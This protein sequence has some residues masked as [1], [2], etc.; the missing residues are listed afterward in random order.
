MHFLPSL[1]HFPLIFLEEEEA[2]NKVRGD[3]RT[4]GD[5]KSKDFFLFFNLPWPPHSGKSKE[6]S[7]ARCLVSPEL[8]LLL[9]P[10]SRVT[11]RVTVSTPLSLSLSLFSFSLSCP[12]VLHKKNLLLLSLPCFNSR[13]NEFWSSFFTLSTRKEG[14][15][16]FSL[17]PLQS[18]DLFLIE[19]GLGREEVDRQ[20][21]NPGRH[22]RVV[23]LT[24][25]FN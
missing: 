8:L 25:R 21:N 17:F 18:Q 15:G 13:S 10:W 16:L 3:N 5:P 24:A 7:L 9:L 20:R 23:C 14:R 6:V 12:P 1:N 22:V 4:P 19:N 11:A 2:A